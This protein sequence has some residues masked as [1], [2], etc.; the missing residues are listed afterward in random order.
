[1]QFVYGCVYLLFEAY[2]VVFTGEHNFQP[3]ILLRLGL[4]LYQSFVPGVL[5]LTY[6]PLV[7]GSILGV[8]GVGHS[9]LAV[10]PRLTC[11]SIS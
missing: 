2:P 5:G 3:G 11:P 7:V 4:D 9:F 1:M 6:L 10:H 8:F